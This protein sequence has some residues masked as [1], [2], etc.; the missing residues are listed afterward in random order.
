MKTNLK[1]TTKSLIIASAICGS[2]SLFVNPYEANAQS[3]YKKVKL[4]SCERNG[5]VY[6]FSN[7]CIT[8]AGACEDRSCPS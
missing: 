3:N 4:T 1:P 2:L 7:D 6:A 5:Q 8:G